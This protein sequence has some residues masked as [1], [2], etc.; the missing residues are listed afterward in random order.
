MTFDLHLRLVPPKS[1]N[2][3]TSSLHAPPIVNHVHMTAVVMVTAENVMITFF[4]ESFR[5]CSFAVENVGHHRHCQPFEDLK[6]TMV[7]GVSIDI[8]VLPCLFSYLPR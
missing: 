2:S 7:A 3:E 4:L 5:S 6:R 1:L 8:L